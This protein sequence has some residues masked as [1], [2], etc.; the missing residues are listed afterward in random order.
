MTIGS[1]PACDVGMRAYCVGMAQ[2][3]ARLCTTVDWDDLRY[4]LA[5]ARQ[6]SL[7]GAARA[8]QT[9][10]PT[11]G[12]R[13]V[14]LELKLDARLFERQPNGL[15]LT[16]AG[17]SI[18]DYAA[19]MEEAALAATRVAS[20]RT[21]GLSGHVRVT[22]TEWFGTRV[23]SPILGAFCAQHPDISVELI[24][25]SR[26][27]SLTRREADLAFRLRRFDQDGLI[28]RKVADVPFGL[29][30]SAGYIERCGLPDFERHG[31]G[32]SLV[33][34]NEALA[35]IA[36]VQ[37]VLGAAKVAYRSNSR[38]GQAAAAAAGAGVVLLP[39]YLGAS[40][41][42]LIKLEVPTPVP[43]RSVWLGLHADS[44]TVP[45]IRASAD[46]I[47]AELERHRL[48]RA[49]APALDDESR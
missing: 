49:P 13:L 47:I 31:A 25:D 11:M 42:S 40:W 18:L 45:R 38:E 3:P 8:L 32:T 37:D 43:D 35:D 6:G 24:T 44:R 9:T 27:L 7:S 30:A 28:Q 19:M 12:R 14:A 4:F 26:L 33:L 15:V 17:S 21:A 16:E 2:P 5:L 20:G 23:L 41:P 46:F 48:T 39:L 10:Q 1:A 36:W 22:A 29:Y 34:P